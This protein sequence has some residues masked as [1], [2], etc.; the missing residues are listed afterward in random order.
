[1]GTQQMSVVRLSSGVEKLCWTWHGKLGKKMIIFFPFSIYES[2]FDKM[3][4]SSIC[5][6]EIAHWVV[7]V[8]L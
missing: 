7:L 2:L 3:C 8:L 1:M 5:N 6:C 4:I